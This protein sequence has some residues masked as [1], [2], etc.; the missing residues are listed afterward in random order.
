MAFLLGKRMNRLSW[1]LVVILAFGTVYAASLTFV[2][3]E[4]DDASSIAYHAL[5]RDRVLQPPYSAYQGGTDLIL[6]L[7]PAREPIL[8]VAAMT[9]SSLA[10]ICVSLLM[11]ALAFDWMKGA[12]D[13]HK[14]LA[15]LVV[16]LA[17]PEL[18]Y[19]GLVY[20][21]TMIAMSFMLAAHLLLRSTVREWERP[22]TIRHGNWLK[23]TI[24]AVLV[25]FGGACRWNVLLYGAVIFADLIITSGL[26]QPNDK[27]AVWN[28]LRF[29]MLWGVLAVLVWG[30]V[31]AA[32]GYGFGAISKTTN[33]VVQIAGV[34][35]HYISIIGAGQALFTPA[36]LVLG[37]WGWFGLPRQLKWL[38]A[39][40]FL[41]IIGVVF[42][43][44][45]TDPKQ[46]LMFVPPLML[47][48]ISG[49]Y[50]ILRGDRPVRL[51]RALQAGVVLL[52]LLPWVFGL[53]ATYG[54]TAW[55][56]GF[57]LRPYDRT[58]GSGTGFAVTIGAG[59]A[60][61]TA[62]GLRPLSGHAAVLFGG[63]WRRFVLRLEEERQQAIQTAVEGRM[64]FLVVQGDTGFA[65]AELAG[66]GFQTRD[67]KAG[68]GDDLGRVRHFSNDNGRHVI[69]WQ[70]RLARPELFQD[71]TKL[72]E[73]I[74]VGGAERVVVQGYPSG[75]RE[76]YE[77]APEAMQELGPTSAIVNLRQLIESNAKQSTAYAQARTD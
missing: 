74:A 21:P 16:L 15:A 58:S 33:T 17:C 12:A 49:F 19:L 32:G 34:E 47:C 55:G 43:L 27:H 51:K 46:F 22:E 7:L 29:G 56:P 75:L 77:A 65:V 39:L 25:G 14:G 11:L 24:S 36:F 1:V 6:R 59:A 53:R 4:G 76:L 26:G 2:Y 72:R 30:V 60:L 62:E 64:P 3:V 50:D 66:M 45:W 5:G 67:A 40:S 28:R 61:P 10:A 69:L 37:L 8:R 31:I 68:A 20:T 63:G 70:L 71:M 35:R 9:I 54:N 73:V 23:M 13:T 44:G 42:R 52:V 41:A 18:F 57:E 38:A 48:L